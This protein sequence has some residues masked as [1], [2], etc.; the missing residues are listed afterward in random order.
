MLKSLKNI[1]KK[2]KYRVNQKEVQ[3]FLL[4][5][6]VG[7]ALTAL[8][9]ILNNNL[10][11][12]PIPSQWRL[13]TE[14][15][16][17]IFIAN[18]GLLAVLKR[19]SLM[20]HIIG[21]ILTV[22]GL[23]R[24]FM[25]NSGISVDNNYELGGIILNGE[26]LYSIL[27][28]TIGIC[29]FIP[30]KIKYIRQVYIFS[31]MLLITVGIS[32]MMSHMMMDISQVHLLGMT[33][34]G[35]LF[36]LLFGLGLLLVVYQN[37]P[38]FLHLPKTAIGIGITGVF[39]SVFV[40]FAGSLALYDNKVDTANTIVRNLSSDIKD[41]IDLKE[42][43]MKRLAIRWTV[44]KDSPSFEEL[45]GIDVDTYMNDEDSLE[46]IVFLNED[47]IP[48]WEVSRNEEI[49]SWALQNISKS[50]TVE[51]LAKD[52]GYKNIK[53][54]FSVEGY[55]NK[56]LM[57]IK[58]NNTSDIVFSVL[59]F[60]KVIREQ[61]NL[62]SQDF[63]IRYSVNNTLL[64][65][66][67]PFNWSDEI[68]LEEYASSKISL[69]NGDF[70]KI[71]VIGGPMML[72]NAASIITQVFALM[73]I[74][75]TYQ[76]IISRILVVVSNKQAS[77]LKLSEQRF[78]SLFDQTPD[79]VFAIDTKGRYKSFN[80]AIEKMMGSS[81][82]KLVGEH[83]TSTIKE[84][85]CSL[86][87][88]KEFEKCFEKAL[89]GV[90]SK[91]KLKFSQ[92]GS[93]V[94]YFEGEMIP[95]VINEDVTGI[96]GITKNV[97]GRVI[98][99]EWLNLMDR[100]LEASSN[101]V[102]IIDPKQKN[103]PIIYVNP[104][105]TDITGYLESE[106]IGHSPSILK[107]KSTDLSYIQKINHAIECGESLSVVLQIL[108]NMGDLIWVQLLLAPVK[109]QSDETTHIVGIINDISELKKQESQLEFQANHDGL[110]GLPNRTLF[111]DRLAHDV[112]LVGRQEGSLAVLFIDLDE[113]K[114][115][116]DSLGHKVGDK[117]L[118]SVANRLNQ[119]LRSSDTLA[120]LGGDEFAMI[121]PYLNNKEEAEKVASRLLESLNKPHR[122]DG[123]ELHVS[124]SIGIAINEKAVK[125]PDE[126]L[127][128]ADMAMYQA[129]QQGK[130]SFKIYS[131]DL[132]VKLADRV[133]MRT[134]LQEAIYS[135]HLSLYYQ[136]QL[137]RD[138]NIDG[139]EALI[140]W[141]HPEKGFIPPNIFIPLAEETG[142]IISLSGWVLNQACSDIK[143]MNDEGLLEG[144]VAINLSPLQ[145]HRPN[146][147]EVLG[148]TLKA[149][150]I[151]P[152]NIE[153]ELTEGI[154]MKDTKGAI[155]ILQE[156]NEMGI[157]VSIDDFG[158]GFSSMSYL[159]DLPI[160][161]IKIDKSFVQKA[162]KDDKNSAICS[163]I[164]TL[165]KELNMKVVS[166]GIETEEQYEHLLSLESDVFQGFL[167]AKP[168]P[169]E[170]LK[171]WVHENKK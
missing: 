170:E 21:G 48:L 30:Y 140:R 59:D 1:D 81:I 17:A 118:V 132:D 71:D 31:G 100:S 155:E 56:A 28:L 168:M 160:H 44:I 70:I 133:I 35:S 80:E 154:L 39:T 111:N 151:A 67:K 99:E 106:T 102:L 165:A 60:K 135:N 68:E 131:G 158:T 7:N 13:T 123:Q 33:W 114:P 122:I 22:L 2:H 136:P 24:W 120:R 53:W 93:E 95:I 32:S 9:S 169:L 142:Q 139:L 85:E 153:L 47:L 105:F 12:I 147:T 90:P 129:K 3:A 152:E 108:S 16:V 98:A 58:L 149:K 91:Y 11:N 75:L 110:T 52:Y 112:K 171:E 146:F 115:I 143:K 73:G 14:G 82:Q 64:K 94:K 162:N 87:D 159:R 18:L 86:E 54:D 72:N 127:Q 29:F 164:I 41:T 51:W 125:Q 19:F 128:K 4:I 83:F 63:I 150:N 34:A 43:L 37:K 40:W 145:F 134:E 124:A 107:S 10:I 119:N 126:L 15:S 42:D 79:P 5:L 113:F 78:R 27:T 25:T 23:Y 76:L 92:E 74:V 161:K 121:L 61:K 6:L 109:V 116:N 20:R 157:N 65:E 38:I 137:D 8:F 57:A 167:F 96:F 156:L 117:M 88:I 49:L 36:S 141:K 130:N 84:P 50:Q 97:T 62:V 104:A 26:F 89:S 148:R 144:R 69:T 55:E 166:E 46:T 163:S 103:W 66:I 101:G 77:E 138:G 45:Q